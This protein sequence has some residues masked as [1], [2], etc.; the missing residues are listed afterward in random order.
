[1]IHPY[2]LAVLWLGTLMTL[3]AGALEW[4]RIVS[5]DRRAQADFERW[6]HEL[7]D[8]VETD[9]DFDAFEQHLQTVDVKHEASTLLNNSESV[10]KSVDDIKARLT[11]TK[12]PA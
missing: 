5:L 3:V 1:V 4:R 8:E 11:P 2:L 6:H 7:P 10:I 12:E 9:F